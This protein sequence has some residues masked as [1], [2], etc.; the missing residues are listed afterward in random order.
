MQVGVLESGFGQTGK[1]KVTFRDGA[2]VKVGDKLSLKL[3]KF[4][5]VVSKKIKP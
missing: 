3:K 1:V 2:V 5:S 4:V